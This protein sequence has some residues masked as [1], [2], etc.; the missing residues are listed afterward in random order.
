MA[1]A[2]D[3]FF[4]WIS[5]ILK[6]ECIS[7]FISYKFCIAIIILIFKRGYSVIYYLWNIYE[8]LF[9][10][11]GV[12]VMFIY[13]TVYAYN[14]FCINDRENCNVLDIWAICGCLKI[15]I[16][17][18]TRRRTTLERILMCFLMPTCVLLPDS[19]VCSSIYSPTPHW[20]LLVVHQ[21]MW[22]IF[23]TYNLFFL[24]LLLDE[25]ETVGLKKKKKKTC[26]VL[27]CLFLF[28]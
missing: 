24:I 14:A 8:T 17:I 1:C 5:K 4:S 27:V 20:T 10:E 23:V 6:A 18:F 13:L 9:K 21:I 12:K 15:Q 28:I 3:F 16:H 22:H 25:K 7:Y 2:I 26:I 19:V 11:S